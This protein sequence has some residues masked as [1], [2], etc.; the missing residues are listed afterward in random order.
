MPFLKMF[1]FFPRWDTLVSLENIFKYPPPTLSPKHPQPAP[2]KPVLW[3]PWL[4]LPH[5]DTHLTDPTPRFSTKDPM[6]RWRSPGRWPAVI[7]NTPAVTTLI[8]W[9]IYLTKRLLWSCLDALWN[10]GI[11]IINILRCERWTMQIW[12]FWYSNMM[13]SGNMMYVSM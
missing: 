9:L 8:S 6:V 12:H 4:V 7:W 3:S 10:K 13:W 1:F 5:Q 2:I 11:C